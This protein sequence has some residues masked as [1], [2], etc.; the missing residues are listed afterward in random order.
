ME[1]FLLL[2]G[3]PTL[4]ETLSQAVAW[5]LGEYGYLSTSNSKESIMIKLLDLFSH[6]TNDITKSQVLVGRI[7]IQR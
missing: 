6:S 3:R 2:I 7:I 1:N 4:P 5:I